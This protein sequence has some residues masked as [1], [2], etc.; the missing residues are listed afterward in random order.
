[1]EKKE[2]L[3]ILSKQVS[4]LAIYQPDSCAFI[5]FFPALELM[6]LISNQRI[7]FRTIY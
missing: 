5:T 7:I 6:K 4:G 3:K 2:R 1:M